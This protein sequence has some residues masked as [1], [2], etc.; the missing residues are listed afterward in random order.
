MRV[1][2]GQAVWQ[3][4]SGAG[5]WSS[6]PP[7]PLP[8]ALRG[9]QGTSISPILSRGALRAERVWLDVGGSARLFGP[10]KA[11]ADYIRADPAGLG[12]TAS[13]GGVLQQRSSPSWAATIGSPTPPPS[14]HG[15]IT[16]PWWALPV[17]DLLYVGPA[18]TRKLGRYGGIHHRPQLA[19]SN[20]GFS[21]RSWARSA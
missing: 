19:Q 11:I 15:R 10:V 12:L 8:G 4:V 5:L 9:G 20:L 6:A 16:A 21:T 18:T 2:T 14:S 13:I 1:K 7:R 3:A 17:S